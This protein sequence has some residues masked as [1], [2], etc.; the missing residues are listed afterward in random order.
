MKDKIK[1]FYK[2]L[3]KYRSQR[4][5]GLVLCEVMHCLGVFGVSL[6]A[7]VFLDYF[8]AFSPIKLKVINVALSATAIVYMMIRIMHVLKISLKETAGYLDKISGNKRQQILS[9][10]E[11]EKMYRGKTHSDMIN[12]LVNK[13]FTVANE[14]L[15]G[16]SLGQVFPKKELKH[17]LLS[18]GL[19]TFLL[20]LFLGIPF[21]MSKVILNRIFHPAEDIPPYSKFVFE[22]TPDHPTVIYG[23]NL[24]LNS[25]ITGASIRGTV[26]L[27]VRQGNSINSVSCFKDGEKKYTQ[28]LEKLSTP[29]EFCFSIGRARSKWRKIEILTLPQIALA[30]VDVTPPEYTHLANKQFIL[31]R[32]ALEVVKGS[33]IKLKITSN[34]PLL[35]GKM[36]Q[37]GMN[38]K[39]KVIRAEKA[40]A[41]SLVFQWT[42]NSKA[43]I[44]VEIKD[45]RGTNSEIPLKFK[46]NMLRDRLPALAITEPDS[47]FLA[48]PDAKFKVKGYAEDDFGIKRVE[49]VRSIIGYR[50]RMKHLGPEVV[51]NKYEFEQEFDLSAL[52]LLPGQI[53]ELYAEASDFNPSLMGVAASD[54]IRIQVISKTD[55][56]DI[57][58]MKSRVENIFRRHSAVQKAFQEMKKNLTEFKKQVKGKQLSDKAKQKEI[59]KLQDDNAN[60]RELLG[61]LAQDFPI[62][63]MEE[64]QKKIFKKLYEHTMKNT[65]TLKNMKGTD[66]NESLIPKVNQM[67][68]GFESQN[69][70]L[71]QMADDMQQLDALVSLMQTAGNFK[72]LV[73]AQEEIVRRLTRF[74]LG[75]NTQNSAMLKILAERED[76][77]SLELKD[78]KEQ[79]IEA[80]NKLPYEYKRLKDDAV[81]FTDRIDNYKI[82]PELVEASKSAEKQ[83]GNK[84]YL[85]AE[86]A[87]EQMQRLKKDDEQKK[88]GKG[89]ANSFIQMLKGQMPG[90]VPQKLRKTAQD[91][92]S[93]ILRQGGKQGGGSGGR[94]MGGAGDPADGYSQESSSMLDIPVVGPERHSLSSEN[95]YAP[96][97]SRMRGKGGRGVT[98]TSISKDAKE[99]IKIQDEVNT[100]T[101]SISLD[102]TP[103]KYKDAVKKYFGI[104][105]DK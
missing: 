77:L 66:K 55:Y 67:L 39:K 70:E 14:C 64:G 52:G 36:V 83:R 44:S 97:H 41:N 94:G 24:E 103:Y 76:I 105:E 57:L 27:Q 80:A 93:T 72:R 13:V 95:P 63:E 54:V 81:L 18:F 33:E 104:S 8:L 60:A 10:Y 100:E 88:S 12:Y 34:R 9:A 62:Y 40:G 32:S 85:H 7:Y 59:E 6:T 61:M 102:D 45:I 53:I 58:R 47:F 42:A 38:G 71:K 74:K 84:A 98:G 43:N 68:A 28:R 29:V 37:T 2:S 79:I 82:I 35:A 11:L 86:K 46:Q 75:K 26:L 49:F 21:Q 96:K 69:N 65:K 56:R 90:S 51:S 23:G 48:T 3:K 50:D 22:I 89:Q 15:K 99:N 92:L 30:Q 73:Q 91:M 19:Q 5:S 25:T 20:V 16:L 4:S 78:L 101:D 17:Q 31:G 87:L 1:F